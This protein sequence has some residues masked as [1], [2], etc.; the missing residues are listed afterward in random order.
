MRNTRETLNHN[1]RGVSRCFPF[2][3]SCFP[4]RGRNTETVLRTN[5]RGLFPKH[6][7]HTETLRN[8]PPEIFPSTVEARSES[9]SDAAEPYSE[10]LSQAFD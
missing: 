9:A 10:G 5:G 1:P 3:V 6:Q 7:K 4:L 2:P 8:T